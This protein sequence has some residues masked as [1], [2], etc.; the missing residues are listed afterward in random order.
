M[1]LASCLPI[2]RNPVNLDV[3]NFRGEV[4]LRLSGL[5]G[6]C[7]L[8]IAPRPATRVADR[9]PQVPWKEGSIAAFPLSKRGDVV[10][11]ED[12]SGRRDDASSNDGGSLASNVV[13]RE[14]Q[15]KKSDESPSVSDVASTSTGSKDVK[16]RLSGVVTPFARGDDSDD[17]IVEEV[18]NFS[19]D[20]DDDDGMEEDDNDPVEEVSYVKFCRGV[21]EN[22]D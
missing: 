11:V 14:V 22:V 16:E 12:V 5:G 15:K 18:V 7:G 10:T 6:G 9:L 1:S 13:D 21:M 20:E 4:F 3:R 19:G 8:V 17:N 2:G